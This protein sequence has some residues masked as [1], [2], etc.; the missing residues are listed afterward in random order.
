M[1]GEGLLQVDTVAVEGGDGLVRNLGS[2]F[3]DLCRVEFAADAWGRTRSAV[4]GYWM[5]EDSAKNTETKQKGFGVSVESNFD[6]FG[7][8]R[9]G[10]R[11]C[12]SGVPSR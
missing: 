9:P 3:A 1:R 5:P 7:L 6:Y 2:G 4:G 11:R 12:P 10:N 8:G